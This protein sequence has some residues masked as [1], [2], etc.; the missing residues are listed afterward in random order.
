MSVVVVVVFSGRHQG[1]KK[2]FQDKNVMN[3]KVSDT[4]VFQVI[5]S[6]VYI[7]AVRL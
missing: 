5:A 6:N 4:V 7:K 1:K 3:N 2:H